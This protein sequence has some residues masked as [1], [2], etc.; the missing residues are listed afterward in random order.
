MNKDL[1][2]A[3][4]VFAGCLLILVVAFNEPDE[5]IDLSD[6]G[7]DIA[8]NDD[9]PGNDSVTDE[10]FPIDDSDP[11]DDPIDTLDPVDDPVIDDPV[12]DEPIV[13]DDPVDTIPEYIPSD[14][15]DGDPL[16]DT[17]LLVDDPIIDD[18]VVEPDDTPVVVED[19]D[20]D[21][22]DFQSDGDSPGSRV[23]GSGEDRLHT[24]ARGDILGTISQQYYG[25]TRYWRLIRDTNNVFEEDL[26]VGQ[27]LVIP[28]VPDLV[29]PDSGNRSGTGAAS[30]ELESGQRRYTVRRGDSYYLIARRELG[31]ASRY[32]ELE[33]LN[34][35]GAYELDAGDVIVLPAADPVRRPTADAQPRDIPGAKIHVVKSGETLGDISMDYYGTAARWKQLQSVNGIVDP[36]RL[37]VGQ[38]LQ[39]PGA[40]DAASPPRSDTPASRNVSGTTYVIKRTDT[41]GEIA[42][43]HYGSAAR[44]KDI[45][46]ANPG[47]N[48]LKLPVGKEIILP[49]SGS[50]SSNSADSSDDDDFAIDFSQ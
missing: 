9:I 6:D 5:I 21:A 35:I 36:R 45:Q 23:A 49:G 38:R 18:P 12:I 46:A 24:V 1:L 27:R 25:T 43:R 33:R 14:P 28:A 8:M 2:V 44:W 34:A 20:T 13:M 40:G 41:L 30:V 19:D 47:L 31:D 15:L 32:K 48:P 3:G 16:D 37:K 39:I 26:Q 50:D 11:V 7:T 29:A 17:P 42:R 22:I 4:A 10:P